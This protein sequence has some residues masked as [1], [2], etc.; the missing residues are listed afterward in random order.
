MDG[1]NGYAPYTYRIRLSCS[2][3]LSASILANSYSY[4]AFVSSI[5]Y[6]SIIDVSA[7]PKH[8]SIQVLGFVSLY[9]FTCGVVGCNVAYTVTS[10]LAGSLSTSHMNLYL[11][12][13]FSV[14]IVFNSF[15][16]AQS[17]NSSHSCFSNIPLAVSIIISKY[18]RLAYKSTASVALNI[19]KSNTSTFSV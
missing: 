18:E 1:S 5:V 19:G 6:L 13:I 17:L 3:L 2:A 8:S 4:I 16:L 11:L 7:I 9:I 10:S 12:L 14:L 15:S